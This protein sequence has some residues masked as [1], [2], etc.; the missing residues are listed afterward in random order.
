MESDAFRSADVGWVGLEVEKSPKS[1][2]VFC[3]IF[4]QF[5]Q[6]LET[7]WTDLDDISTVVHVV[8]RASQKIEICIHLA[9]FEIPRRLI[10]LQNY[11]A[12]L[13]KVE[14]S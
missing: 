5:Y 4:T 12:E 8:A 7:H 1:E 2:P 9:T 14:I 10:I 3:T 13:R 11:F 6:F